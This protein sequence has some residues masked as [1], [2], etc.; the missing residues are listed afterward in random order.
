[1]LYSRMCFCNIFGAE[2]Q[3]AEGRRS[4]IRA[5]GRGTQTPDYFQCEK[6][7]RS[8]LCN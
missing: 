4:R 6:N 8:H 3:G 7:E 5:E 1:M 2:D